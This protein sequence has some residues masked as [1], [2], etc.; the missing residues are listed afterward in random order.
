MPR[1]DLHSHTFYSPDSRMRFEDIAERCREV[2]IDV[3]ATTDHHTA[4]GALA[5]Q[6]W[7]D[8][9]ADH[10]DVIVGE[11][12][13][14]D[15]G[16]VIGLYLTETIES[17][18]RL[19]E[20][21]DAIRAQGGLFLLEHPF[22]PMRH[23]LDGKSWEV[24]PDIIETFNARTRLKGA[25]AKAAELARA[26]KTPTCACS[27][28]HT[29]GEFGSAYTDVPDFDI[30]SPK[31]LLAALEEGIQHETTSPIWVSVHSTLAKGLHKLGF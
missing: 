10:L 9:H 8:K 22:D 28:A 30:E 19:T 29:L 1:L 18:C 24:E 25:N 3:I 17:P 2:G 4:E 12:I 23:G 5:F 16:E 15:Q 27:D 6:R 20:A 11:E 14:T 21:L 7:A 13:M 26:K 31:E